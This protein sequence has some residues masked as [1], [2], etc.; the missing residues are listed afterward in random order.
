MGR[1]FRIISFVN[2]DMSLCLRGCI[3]L[4]CRVF[5]LETRLRMV[6]KMLERSIGI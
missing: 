5:N 6:Q 2:C 1:L 3:L 4:N